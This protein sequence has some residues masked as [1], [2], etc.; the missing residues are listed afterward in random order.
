M[1]ILEKARKA[2]AAKQVVHNMSLHTLHQYRVTTIQQV[3]DQ[4][5]SAM[6]QLKMQAAAWLG[7]VDRHQDECEQ[8]L[9]RQHE[10]EQ[11]MLQAPQTEERLPWGGQMLIDPNSSAE[12]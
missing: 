2:E 11:H 4:G 6:G 8:R 5:L 12:Y 9:L 10:F 1:A 3:E 7:C